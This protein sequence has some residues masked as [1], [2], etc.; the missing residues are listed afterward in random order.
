MFKNIHTMLLKYTILIKII[1]KNKKTNNNNND[2]FYEKSG[3]SDVT[4]DIML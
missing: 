2:E 1:I 3:S 4:Y